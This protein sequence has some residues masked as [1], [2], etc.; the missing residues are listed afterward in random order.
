MGIDLSPQFAATR[1]RPMGY[2]VPTIV[3]PNREWAIGALSGF[4]TYNELIYPL[5]SL[6]KTVTPTTTGTTG[7]QW[8]FDWSPTSVET[9]KSYTLEQGDANTRAHKALGAVF[10]GLNISWPRNGD[11]TL[12]GT[13]LAQ[14][15]SDGITL[16]PALVADAP[17]PMLSTQIDVYSDAT[18]AGLGTTKLLRC[19]QAGFSLTNMWGPLWVLNTAQQSFVNFNQI[20]PTLQVTLTLEADSAG[21]AY[22]LNMRAGSSVFIQIKATGAVI[23]AGPATYLAKFDFA[24]KIPAQPAW[25]ETDG[26]R[27]AAWTFDVVSDS[28]SGKALRVTLVNAALTL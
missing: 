12:G 18:W 1:V 22:L 9:V 24:G 25:G 6:L 11:P 23:G 5:A 17:I 26:V 13:V 14:A 21:M 10:N 16:T 15:F 7:Q 27:T 4:P 3:A 20:E 19:V 8:E 28:V 2:K